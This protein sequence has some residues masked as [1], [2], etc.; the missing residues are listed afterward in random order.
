[1]V[2]AVQGGKLT[3]IYQITT[4]VKYCTVSDGVYVSESDLSLEEFYRTCKTF[5]RKMHSQA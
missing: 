5:C 2:M 3:V 4:C 1:M